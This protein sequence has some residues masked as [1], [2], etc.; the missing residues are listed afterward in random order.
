MPDEAEDRKRMAPAMAFRNPTAQSAQAGA[1]H[2]SAHVHARREGPGGA[3]VIVRDSARA[4][5]M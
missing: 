4:A 1:D 2:D 5:G 3:A